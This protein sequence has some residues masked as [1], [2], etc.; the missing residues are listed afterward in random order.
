MSAPTSSKPGAA[1]FSLVEISHTTPSFRRMLESMIPPG[2]HVHVDDAL[3]ALKA[4]K[5]LADAPD[6]IFAGH[7]ETDSRR[8]EAFP[9]CGFCGL[10]GRGCYSA[11][12][13]TFVYK[14]LDV[15]F[16]GIV[17][18]GRKIITRH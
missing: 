16:N 8:E 7:D 18:V 13:H 11:H 14:R 4:R 17:F 5:D 9:G 15:R 6:L 2:I 12:L 3:R 1:H 10:M